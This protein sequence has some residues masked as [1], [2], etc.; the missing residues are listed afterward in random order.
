MAKPCGRDLGV[1][2]N[3]AATSGGNNAKYTC[4]RRSKTLRI[5]ATRTIMPGNEILVAYGRVYVSKIKAAVVVQ[6]AKQQEV[7]RNLDI[8]A[9]VSVAGGAVRRLL[10]SKCRKVLSCR[11]RLTHARC[12]HD[13]LHM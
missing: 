6:R 4:N 2:A 3:T 7:L 11:T 1:L 12:C 13:M 10:C 5:C 9:P 8:I